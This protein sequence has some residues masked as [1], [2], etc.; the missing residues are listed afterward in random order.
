[1]SKGV[2][3]IKE[4]PFAFRAYDEKM[5]SENAVNYLPPKKRKQISEYLGNSSI[6]L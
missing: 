6:T 3:K 5:K 1:M 4:N 2:S